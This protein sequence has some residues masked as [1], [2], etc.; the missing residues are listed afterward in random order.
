MTTVNNTVE[1][2]E[3]VAVNN[4]KDDIK[5]TGGNDIEG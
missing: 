4:T 1:V 2:V 3:T 5:D